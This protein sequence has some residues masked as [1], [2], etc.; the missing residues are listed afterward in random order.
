MKILVTGGSGFIGSH[1]VDELIERGHEVIS[2]DR[3]MN[4]KNEKARYFELD[5]TNKVRTEN[6][7]K[8]IGPELVIHLAG[9]LGT[10]ELW[11]NI[12]EAID[13][14]LHGCVNVYQA[15]ANIGCNILSVDV[16]SRWS[17]IYT[18]TKRCGTEL[19]FA[20][21]N[22]YKIKTAALRI[23]NVFGPHQSNKI[24]KIVPR[25]IERSLQDSEIQVWG[26]KSADLVYVTDVAKAFGLA[27]ENMDKVDQVDGVFIGSGENRTVLEVAQIIS[28]KI[29]KGKIVQME[30]RIGEE[31]VEAGFMYD[32]TAYRLL[33]WKPEFKF[34]DKIDE[35]IEWYKK[36][37]GY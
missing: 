24:I 7:I 19:L 31:K 23:F 11:Q 10:T 28:S 25:F 35:V 29:G 27:A 26:N 8:E 5:V 37:L 30:P 16:G 13:V 17:S 33:G 32:D 36:Y 12:H 2:V 20:F 3:S 6:L 34:E 9:L 22:K 14:N 21:G 4:W 15:C 1:V 18:I